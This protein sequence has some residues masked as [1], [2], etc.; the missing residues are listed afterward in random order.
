[1]L[2]NLKHFFSRA[3]NLPGPLFRRARHFF[4]KRLFMKTLFAMLTLVFVSAFAG[5]Y[6]LVITC[7]GNLCGM[8]VKAIVSRDSQ[9]SVLY[10]SQFRRLSWHRRR[11][12]G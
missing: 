1:M 3:F 10:E 5:A 11:N 12:E 4:L 9:C 2:D 8:D 7:E 6:D